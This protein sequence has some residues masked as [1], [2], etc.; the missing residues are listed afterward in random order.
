M[1][2]NILILVLFITSLTISCISYSQ[3]LIV[4]NSSK[5]IKIHHRTGKYN[6]SAC[7]IVMRIPVE[8]LQHH[9]THGDYLN[10]STG[11]LCETPLCV[12]E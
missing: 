6:G 11:N 8:D 10:H 4:D 9:L 3:D 7:F 1:K 2:T 5:T 12:R